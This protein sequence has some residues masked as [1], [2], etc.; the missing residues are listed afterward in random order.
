MNETGERQPETEKPP[1]FYHASANRH[2]ERLEPRAETVRDEA[3]G[4]VVFAT[5]EKDLA[6]TF[7]L[8]KDD[9][10]SASGR[11]NG[12]AF[13]LFADRDK[14][15]A[16]DHGGTL[17]VLPAESFGRDDR[18]EHH[19]S[20]WTSQEAVVPIERIDYDSA[21]TAMQENGVRVHFVDAATLAEFQRANPERKVEMLDQ[22]GA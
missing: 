10:W 19:R 13:A 21:L 15:A 12:R 22:L 17:Y 9:S 14:F 3:E 8:P 2:L 7:M 6:S 20:E 16:L 4:A 1:L 11:V 5:P 18:D